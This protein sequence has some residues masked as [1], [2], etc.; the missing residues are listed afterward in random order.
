M[1]KSEKIKEYI[2]PDTGEL[3]P[4]AVR[5][6]K[7]TDRGF[8]KMWLQGVLTSLDIVS[9]KKT[10]VA[11]WLIDHMDASNT[12]PFT[13]RQIADASGI[14]YKTVADTVRTLKDADFLREYGK[15][16]MINP[17]YIFKGTAPRRLGV[18]SIYESAEKHEPTT[19][20]QLQTLQASLLRL[21]R[22]EQRIVQKID[23]ITNPSSAP[24]D[25]QM[26]LDD[27]QDQDDRQKAL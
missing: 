3:I 2:D 25:G 11:F 17:S 15:V 4:F 19:A 20:E 10:K 14:S 9:N 26:S 5:E 27:F 12:I 6:Q 16:L 7:A 22:E 21:Q 23:A 1:A 8:Y 24:V 18:A 13:Y